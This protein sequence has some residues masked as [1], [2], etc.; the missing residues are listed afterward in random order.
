MYVIILSLTSKQKLGSFNR[1]LAV[2]P[3]FEGRTKGAL[4]TPTCI[5]WWLKLTNLLRHCGF[6]FIYH[7]S[8][9]AICL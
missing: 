3:T 5:K 7:L 4:R 1:A 6:V 2:M 9:E 8:Y